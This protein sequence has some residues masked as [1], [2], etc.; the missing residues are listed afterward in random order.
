MLKKL[1][2]GK[3]HE[4]YFLLT[5]SAASIKSTIPSQSLIAAVTSSEKFTWPNKKRI[6]H[7]YKRTNSHEKIEF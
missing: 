3:L 4:K 6:L 5:P 7:E 1:N 2:N